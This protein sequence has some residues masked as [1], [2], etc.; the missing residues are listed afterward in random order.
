MSSSSA[1]EQT[2]A[3]VLKLVLIILGSAT[4]A[5]YIIGHSGSLKYLIKPK[6]QQERKGINPAFAAY[7][8]AF[9]G[10]TLA[11]ASSVRIRLSAEYNDSTRTGKA[12][13]PSLLKIEPAISGK[14][15]WADGQTIVFRPDA[16]MPS[17]AHY[18]V[19]LSLGKII[20]VKAPELQSFAFGFAVIRQAVSAEFTR[21]APEGNKAVAESAE[22]SANMSIEGVMHTADL[23]DVHKTEQCLHVTQNGNHLQ[24]TWT[25]DAEGHL[26]FFTAH[27]A[28]RVPG[29]TGTVS[30]NTNGKPI[31]ADNENEEIIEIAPLDSFKVMR[32]NTV[33]VPEQYLSIFLSD[34][35]MPG[36]DLSGLVSIGNVSEQQNTSAII[37]DGCELK[38]YPASQL[39]GQYNVTLQ[40]GIKNSAGKKLANLTYSVTFDAMKPS[41]KALSAGWIVPSPKGFFMT[42]E[43]VAVK[44]V[45]VRVIKIPSANVFGIMSEK[46][47][48]P[49]IDN[50]EGDMYKVGLPVLEKT[51]SLAG[52][53]HANLE[54]PNRYKLDL[55]Q[56]IKTDPG[57][58]Y[59]VSVSFTHKQIYYDC[60]GSRQASFAADEMREV[61]IGEADAIP[62]AFDDAD[63]K[64]YLYYG[65]AYWAGNNSEN[66]D[67]EAGN[68][69]YAN[70]LNPCKQEYGNE[71]V[72]YSE[73]GQF[74]HHRVNISQNLLASDLGLLAK[75]GEDGSLF[76]SATNI[77]TTEPLAGAAIR[78]ID[79]Q[80]RPLGNL[81]TNDS[82]FA[83][84]HLDRKP[85]FA[86]AEW[87]GQFAYLSLQN[88]TALSMSN[89]ETEGQEVKKGLKGFIYGERGVWRPGDSLYLSFII[90][91]EVK[92]KAL[93]APKLRPV[94]MELQDPNGNT[95]QRMVRAEETGGIYSFKTKTDAD[96]PTGLWLATVSAGGSEF[97]KSIRIETIK[98]NRLKINADFGGETLLPSDVG[99][100]ITMGVNWLY[101][102]TG[103]N[104]AARVEV[105]HEK[106][107]TVFKGYKGYNFD[108]QSRNVSNE[109]YTLAEAETDSRGQLSFALKLN[110]PE[111]APGAVKTIIK[112]TVY[113]PGGEFSTDRQ[114]FTWYP[115]NSF[116]GIKLPEESGSMATGKP[117]SLQIATLDA[118]GK[119]VS[120]KLQVS[121]HKLDWRW[122]WQRNADNDIYLSTEVYSNYKNV[123]L[124]SVNGKAVFDFVVNRGDWGRYVID[125]QDVESGHRSTAVVYMD[126]PW[127]DTEGTEGKEFAAMLQ[128][129]AD[130]VKYKPG[131]EITL[132]VPAAAGSSMLISIENGS[133]VIKAFR[134]TA[135]EA[136]SDIGA[137]TATLIKFTATADMAPNAYAHITLLRK[138]SMALN[139]LPLRMYGVVG[140]N[141]ENPDT[142][143]EPQIALPS[144]LNP[145]ESFDVNVS[146]AKGRPMSYTLAIVDEGLLD[147]TRFKTPDPHYAF[148]MPS[149]LGVRTWDVFDNVTQ[150]DAGE[151]ARIL[152]TGGDMELKAQEGRNAIRFKP[153]VRYIGPFALAKGA[154]AKHRVSMPNYVGSVRVMLVAAQE[155][156]FGSSEKTVPVKQ[157]LMLLA[158]LPRV[159][160]PGEEVL[161][162]VNVFA[163]EQGIGNTQITVSTNNMAMVKGNAS[164]SI[165]FTGEDEKTVFFRVKAAKNTGVARFKISAKSGHGTAFTDVELQVRNPNPKTTRVAALELEPGTGGTI[166]AEVFGMAGSNKMLVELSTFPSLNLGQR[167][168]YLVQ[169][170]YG[171]LEQ[172]VSSAFPQLYLGALI[173]AKQPAPNILERNIKAAI[174]RLQRFRLSD[175][176]FSYWPGDPDTDS[177]T[178][179]YAGHFLLEARA[180]GFKVPD[181]MLDKWLAWQNK[182]ANSFQSEKI[183]RGDLIQAYRLYTLAL[184]GKA[185]LRAMNRLRESGRLSAEA[186]WQLASAYQLAG[187]PNAADALVKNL[188]SV[189]GPYSESDVTYGSDVRD[190]AIVLNAL[191]LMNRRAEATALARIIAGHIGNGEW[192]STQ[193]TAFSLMALTRY[194]GAGSP[195]GIDAAMVLNGQATELKSPASVLQTEPGGS[196]QQGSNQVR[197]TNKGKA[198]LFVRVISSG[199]PPAGSEKAADAGIKMEVKYTDAVGKAIDPAALTQGTDF[200]AVITVTHP[201]VGPALRNLALTQIVPGGWEITNT[202]MDETEAAFANA[203]FDRR[204]IRD[205]RTYIF[206]GL[207]PGQRKVFKS[208]LKAAYA[209]NYYLPAISCE[210]MYDAGVSASTTGKWIE[211]KQDAPTAP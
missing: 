154:K 26:H 68:D 138:H 210:A 119:P 70:R 141:V 53:G 30:I 166:D 8:S 12:L 63:G 88:G 163:T 85:A 90:N 112:T 152:A 84:G 51:I 61:E 2:I 114:I 29:Q 174:D 40:P 132:S 58:L 185:N 77:S 125:V 42:F 94:V 17:G 102:A 35:V 60:N 155:G 175:G 127:Y 147:I 99:K 209:G 97:S 93:A 184:G 1:P 197:I 190:D 179:S 21:W 47:S 73:G 211:V 173:D 198:K 145:L 115:Y 108:D 62:D 74:Y 157:N 106:T 207:K 57:A 142:R 171:C 130:K 118:S 55:S 120:S 170:P 149:A 186:A 110:K 189:I 109:P 122:W 34:P 83:T 6:L 9:S 192:M 32:F 52:T 22:P 11:S 69:Y 56:F 164:Q 18:D 103:K 36:S 193:T 146:E 98:P 113:E 124:E 78:L 188:P 82:G 50:P 131:D 194:Y 37:A 139:G 151:N 123:A 44:A 24:I 121:M 136:G 72:I 159:L 100:R 76:F 203:Q 49:G 91:E 144:S 128:F 201:G 111:A 126:S 65:T 81:V 10:G 59:N 205:D 116:V 182:T 64:E 66:Y 43:A 92:G 101:G 158:T 178:T 48:Y 39:A 181:N 195:S 204:D 96:A 89:F 165:S 46:Y 153:V 31:G 104:L 86:I 16:P 107:P 150:A 13:D 80:N 14:A 180:K 160:G 133:R 200:V 3:S 187:Q 148:N 129:S 5:A 23:A 196:R 27:G 161:L 45:N 176:S 105:F 191:S 135:P 168:N 87:Q 183:N 134:R 137:A 206:F 143:L 79:R 177:W 7:I 41:L 202:R 38:I 15:T 156:R 19:A 67:D 33:S 20:T 172:T 140:L 208:V 167:L 162:P 199:V 169:Y 75:R 25:H 117:Q 71:G 95:V 4:A 54:R 28:K